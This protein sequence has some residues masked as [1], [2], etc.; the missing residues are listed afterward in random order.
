MPRNFFR[1]IEIAFPIEN[2]TARDRII[3]EL[4]RLTLADNIKARFLRPDGSYIHP[5]PKP[6]EKPRRSQFESIDLAINPR[7]KIL[8]RMGGPKRKY[9]E[10]KLA[11]NPFRS[12]DRTPDT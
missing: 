3:N 10:V 2:G 1:R 11:S 6:G 9:P 8:Q 4:L 7:S 12:Q 5:R